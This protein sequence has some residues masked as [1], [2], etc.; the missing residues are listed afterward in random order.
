MN[1]KN[2]NAK[3]GTI[4]LF[5]LFVGIFLWLIV[6]FFT[7]QFTGR[8]KGENLLARA[9][10][11]HTQTEVIP[12]IRGN[13][14]DRNGNLLAN[15]STSYTL[16]AVLSPKATENPKNP[17]HVLNPEMTAMELAKYIPLTESEI[18]KTLTKNNDPN[19]KA[20]YQVEFGSAGK[21]ISSITKKNIDDLQLPGINFQAE[22]KRFYP[23][24]EFASHVIGFVQP[25]RDEEKKKSLIT[26]MV[27]LEK[28][29]DDQ[30]K[31]IDGLKSY[32]TD[33]A[34]RILPN[35][36]AE[37]SK[38]QNG[39]DIQTTIDK[40]IQIFLEEA[41]AAANEK[42][43][44]VKMIGIV[45][46]AKTGAVIAMSQ[47]PSFDLNTKEGL[48]NNW[49]NLAI[50]E[51]FEPG[52]TFKIFTLAAAV[53]EGVFNKEET[54][55]S[56]SYQVGNQVIHDHNGSGWGNINYMQAV[57]YSSNVGFAKLGM[58]KVGPEK[59]R[60]YL[61]KFGLDEPTGIDL[62]GEASSKIVYKYKAEQV[63]TMFG[64]GTAVTPIQQVQGVTAI[65]NEGN[66]VQP[67]VVAK[68]TDHDSGKVL[69]NHETK[70]VGTPITAETAKTVLEC[71]EQVVSNDKATGK[72]YRIEGYSIAGKTGTAQIP[73]PAG[74]GYLTGG[75]NHIFSFLG[76]APADN[77][78]II[79]YIAVQQP[80]IPAGEPGN[81]ATSFIF[82]AVMD[83]TL[84][85]LSINPED[86]AQMPSTTIPDFSKLSTDAINAFKKDH[87]ELQ[88][89]ILGPK[90][91]K[92]LNQLPLAG[93]KVFAGDRIII[94]N[95][96]SAVLPDLTGWSYRDVMRLE[97][98]MHIQVDYTGNG[99]VT[100]QNPLSGTG[101]LPEMKLQVNLAPPEQ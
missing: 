57:L 20:L 93:E 46:D 45:V 79:T 31:G 48:E 91:G 21:G 80:N 43:Q 9:T 68:I 52:S 37:I 75:N 29:Y 55:L 27:G 50:E 83:K 86:S 95:E 4:V 85:Y 2:K 6:T 66:M 63:T 87:P 74:G 7:I 23:N 5:L 78:E 1:S 98:L 72:S 69:Y 101:I 24:G 12:A 32:Q 33:Q 3:F 19:Q 58:E 42:Y 15:D 35:S 44:P 76:M 34:R 61:T 11:L 38:P 88:T 49:H 18:L 17:R 82:K 73:D 90:D 16:Y 100:T 92:V 62:L 41:L 64:Q 25:E 54:Y 51:S 96:G 77:P 36:E 53:N 94:V 56:G 26:G 40:K 97:Q 65:T 8:A 81:A 28:K 14:L 99:F 10:N 70:V 71:L 60:E 30:L 59:M 67:Y 89:V 13:I 22:T 84:K 39:I 47:R